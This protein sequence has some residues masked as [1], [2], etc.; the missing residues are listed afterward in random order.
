MNTL[1]PFVLILIIL[2]PSL[3]VF[4]TSFYLI[5]NFL[6]HSTRSKML[7]LKK[8]NSE[9]S[10]PLRLQAFERIVLFLERISPN[11]LIIR[12]NTPTMTARQLQREL[13]LTIRT[14]FE[15]NLSQQI[16]MSSASWEAVKKAKEEVT[17][18]VNLVAMKVKETAPSNELAQLIIEASSRLNKL[19]T[20]EA[21]EV[22]KKE[23]GQIF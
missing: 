9:T 13:L 7:E 3:I 17:Q 14:E 23:V 2:L 5:K 19:P 16:Y 6:D 18:I 22:L 15:H 12:V 11:N 4:L 1:D 20:T 21:I 10:L 8:K